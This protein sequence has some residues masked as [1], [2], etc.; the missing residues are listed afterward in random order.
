MR[1][2]E[3]R[4]ARYEFDRDILKGAINPVSTFLSLSLSLSLPSSFLS[5]LTTS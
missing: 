3:V 5:S 1:L 4:K 2:A